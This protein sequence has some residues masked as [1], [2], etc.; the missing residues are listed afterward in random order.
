MPYVSTQNLRARSLSMH[1]LPTLRLT[2]VS[3]YI[4]PD[5]L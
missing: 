2:H 3:S 1:M 4:A 5:M